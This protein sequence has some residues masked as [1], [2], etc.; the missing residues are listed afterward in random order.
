M[1]AQTRRERLRA[2]TLAEARTTARRLLVERGTAAVTVNAV[3]REMGLSGPALYRYFTGHDELVEAM[4]TD[5]YQELGGAVAAA[6][7]LH[8]D[9]LAGDRLLAMCRALRGWAV[10]HPA[11]FEWTFARPLRESRGHLPD[12]PRQAA[13]VGF[14]RAFL[15][16]FAALWEE[17][18]YPVPDLA[19]LEPSLR[20]QLVAYSARIDGA[21]PPAAA[22][23]FLTTW[24]RIYGL[25]CMEVLQQLDFAYTDVGPLFEEYLRGACSDLGLEYTPPRA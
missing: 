24:V 1:T 21:L 15:G 8:A 10:A 14:E 12:S 3:A 6:R 9:G 4:I 5:F 19:D 25:L 16:E 22:H 2:A 23:V 7:D 17:A 20:D 11:E 18:P 13:G